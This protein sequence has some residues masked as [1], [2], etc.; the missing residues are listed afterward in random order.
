M[1]NTFFISDTHF[2]HSNILTFL[3]AD[4]T[5][6]REFESIEEHDEHIVK[7]WNE[8]VRPQDKVYHL[9]DVVINRKAL[10]I[11]S[12]LNGHKRLVRGNHDIF[13]TKEYLEYFEEIYGCRVIDRI[14]FTH[15]PIHEDCLARFRCNVHGHLHSN[16]V[17]T[18]NWG[19]PKIDSRYMNVSCEQVNYT[20]ISLDEINTI[21]G[22]L[23]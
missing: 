17:L 15:I 14:I 3:R 6:L 8:V 13:R 12:R 21:R 7:C 16:K 10:P 18:T 23:E 1:V 5:K 4:G 19:E 22:T 20:P 2:G 11:F 9:G